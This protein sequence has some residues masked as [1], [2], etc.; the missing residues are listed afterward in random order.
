V[1]GKSKK[2]RRKR[3]GRGEEEE[4]KKAEEAEKA[5]FKCLSV[6]NLKKKIINK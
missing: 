5:T 1:G 3:S 4:V 2:R 6:R